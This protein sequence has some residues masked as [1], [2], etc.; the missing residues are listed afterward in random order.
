MFTLFISFIAAG[1]VASQ[2]KI[3]AQKAIFA[4]QICPKRS[5]ILKFS[6]N[7]IPEAG[8]RS[9]DFVNLFFDPDEFG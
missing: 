7:S 4:V 3:Y 2:N 5:S 9:C 8:F 6:F 1:T